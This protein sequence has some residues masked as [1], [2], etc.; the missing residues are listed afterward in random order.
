MRHV[1]LAALAAVYIACGAAAAQAQERAVLFEE[2]ITTQGARFDG[3]VTW[4]LK[5]VPPGPGEAAT[6]RAV[7]AAITIPDRQMTATW[8]LRRNT[9]KSLPASHTVDVIFDLPGNAA[10][11]DFDRLAGILMKAEETAEGKPLAGLAVK[12]TTNYFLF[13]L[14]AGAADVHSNVE[15]LETLDWIDM[16]ITRNDGRRL[17]LS[18]NKGVSGIR[19]FDAA[20]AAWNDAAA[21]QTSPHQ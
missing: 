20:F 13:G 9:D 1:A 4:S 14:S 16:P 7:E 15:L 18:V 21:A 5:D 19:A 10:G 3:H 2:N 6:E 12:V 8:T 17:V 11:G